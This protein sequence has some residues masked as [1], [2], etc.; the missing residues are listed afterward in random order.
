V[1]FNDPDIGKISLD[2]AL[3]GPLTNLY[4]RN[5][6]EFNE[7]NL[8]LLLHIL[9]F[10]KDEYS[11]LIDDILSGI[12]KQINF[13]LIGGGYCLE[14]YLFKDLLSKGLFSEKFINHNK[15]IIVCLWNWLPDEERAKIAASKLKNLKNK[16][17]LLN[18]LSDTYIVTAENEAS[19]VIS[20][21]I[22][23]CGAILAVLSSQGILAST[24]L[25]CYSLL[26]LSYITCLALF[27]Y[28]SA[29]KKDRV[30]EFTAL[31]ISC[32]GVFMI[33]FAT[34]IHSWMGFGYFS[35]ETLKSVFVTLA[36][37]PVL[38]FSSGD[39]KKIDSPDGVTRSESFGVGSINHDRDQKPSLD[40]KVSDNSSL[41]NL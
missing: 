19:V 9:Y 15:E 7:L 10:R 21:M 8:K 6:S 2:S 25:L 17:I 4:A 34:A 23:G 24:Y 41:L 18:S 35:V 32:C 31:T 16:A 26:M 5:R 39:N 22:V 37:S 38:L 30:M 12:S 33:P 36:V 11:C 3:I 13:S 1:G 28:G 40:E 29:T 14:D 27:D 20:P